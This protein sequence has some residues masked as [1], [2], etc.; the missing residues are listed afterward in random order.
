M[1]SCL[2]LTDF[3]LV[4]WVTAFSFSWLVFSFYSSMEYSLLFTLAWMHFWQQSFFCKNPNWSC[5]ST[6]SSPLRETPGEIT[7]PQIH[8]RCKH[9][10]K[11]YAPDKSLHFS[12]WFI[13]EYIVCLHMQE[14]ITSDLYFH[15]DYWGDSFTLLYIGVRANHLYKRGERSRN[16]WQ[17]KVTQKGKEGRKKPGQTWTLSVT[18][19]KLRQK[20]FVVPAA[21]CHLLPALLL[22]LLLYKSMLLMP[23]KAKPSSLGRLIR[24]P[25]RHGIWSCVMCSLMLLLQTS[26]CSE[27]LLTPE[28]KARGT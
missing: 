5:S 17:Y 16:G 11:D 15:N 14:Q 4:L 26:H 2:F 8:I 1:G 10:P 28:Q 6:P 20:S 18:R 27:Q 23:R 9:F 7:L 25:A 3:F 19:G 12:T 24:V 22:D 21:F 13:T